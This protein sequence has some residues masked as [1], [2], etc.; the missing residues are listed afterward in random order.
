MSEINEAYG[1][2]Y[3]NG[4]HRQYTGAV[5]QYSGTQRDYVGSQREYT[6]SQRDYA[7]SRP[8]SSDE[9]RKQRDRVPEITMLAP[10]QI[11][12]GKIHYYD[13]Y[14]TPS[15]RALHYCVDEHAKHITMHVLTRKHLFKMF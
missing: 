11:K 2:Q 13:I 12:Q 5:R 7:T 1:R 9:K 4:A 14:V 10:A 3:S 6:S 8:S 15:L